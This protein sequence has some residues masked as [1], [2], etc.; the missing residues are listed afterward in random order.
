MV[1]YIVTTVG[2]DLP[3]DPEILFQEFLKTNWDD[4]IAGI[5]KANID[6]GYEPDANSISPYIVKIEENFTDV[7]GIDITDRY[8]EHSMVMDCKIWERDSTRYRTTANTGRYKLRRYIEKF[9]KI[10]RNNMTSEKI[11]H[12]Y[13][14]GSRNIPEPQRVDWHYCIVT[15]RMVTYKVLV[16]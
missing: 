16:P 2:G 4:G 15:F 8:D 3:D 9:I 13:L 6:F 5:L 14:L 10:N 12:L 7:T 1:D 11:K